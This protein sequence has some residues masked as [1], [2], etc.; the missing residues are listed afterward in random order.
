MIT[1]ASLSCEYGLFFSQS[2]LQ[3]CYAALSQAIGGTRMQ[4]VSASWVG[5][6]SVS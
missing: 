6:A 1:E 2:V 4:A 3:K 5:R